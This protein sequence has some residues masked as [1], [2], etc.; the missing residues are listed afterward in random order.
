MLT[1]NK[2]GA[3]HPMSFKLATYVENG[4]LYVGLIT[5]EEGY[6]EPWSDLT[7]N[8]GVKCEPNCAFIDTNNNG[9][10]IVDWLISMQLGHFTGRMEA[11]GWCL[12]PEIKFDMDKL[13]QHVTEDYREASYKTLTDAEYNVLNKITSKTKTDCWFWLKKDLNG[14]NYV[15]DLEEGKRMCL[16]TG[17]GLLCEALDCQENYDSCCLTEEEDKIFKDLLGK[18][19]IKFE[20]Q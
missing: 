18:L 6:P 20:L 10:E 8:L 16:Q 3:V 2:Y 14:V 7:V 11:S 19:S 1:L 5:H 4:N 13:M 12:Y 15:W 9:D 17:V